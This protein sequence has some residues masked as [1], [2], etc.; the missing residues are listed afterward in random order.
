MGLEV[1]QFIADLVTNWPLATD[2]VREGDDHLRLLKRVVKNTFPNM[3]AACTVTPEQLNS[4]P[5]NATE[6]VEEMLKHLVP[7]GAIQMWSGA[8]N[9]VPDGWAVCDGRTVTGYGVV[10]DLRDRFIVGVSPT[11]AVGATGG[12]AT[13]ATDGS[14]D[15]T[16]TVNETVLT[17]AQLPEHTHS[18]Y[19]WNAT[20][21]GSADG[22]GTGK[23]FIG[24]V[25]P[26]GEDPDY[27]YKKL[28]SEGQELIQSTGENEGHGHTTSSS[29]THTH[30]VSTMP[31]W[32]ALMFIIKVTE[33]TEPV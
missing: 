33:Y 14:G 28:N 11:K 17:E 3:N 31:P 24:Q 4:L 18:P 25:G 12:S 26:A 32:Y 5:T 7:K 21:T 16:H 23:A 22:F 19:V 29:E 8:E 20:G 2:K 9:A 6:V 15:H 13:T 1:A 27:I 30:N 10:P